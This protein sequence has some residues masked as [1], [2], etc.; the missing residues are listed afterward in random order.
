MDQLSEPGTMDQLSEPGTMDQLSE[1]GTRPTIGTRNHTNYRNQEPYQ[2]SEPGT[3]PTIGTRNQTN[4]RNQEPD[5]IHGLQK[6]SLTPEAKLNYRTSAPV[7]KQ[8]S[9]T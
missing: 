9:H 4:Y 5:N 3:R 8:C 1:P 7:Q 2:L 6:Q